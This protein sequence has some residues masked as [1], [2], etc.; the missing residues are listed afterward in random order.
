MRNNH[1]NYHINGSRIEQEQRCQENTKVKYIE[2]LDQMLDLFFQE[3][4]KIGE[5]EDR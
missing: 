2:M 3:G 5:R 4:Q 1:E